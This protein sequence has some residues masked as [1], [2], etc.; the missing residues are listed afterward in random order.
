M[1]Q[2]ASVLS[3]AL[4]KINDLKSARSPKVRDRKAFEESAFGR[5]WQSDTCYMPNITENGVSRRTYLVMIVDDFSRMIVG[6][7]IFY[8]DNAYNFQILLKTAIETYG[9]PSKLYLDNGSPYSNEQL[10]RICASV[11]IVEFI[12]QSATVRPKARLREISAP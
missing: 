7:R 8:S 6:G 1:P 12:R 5:L 2:P 10:S 4:M 9:I 11:G 3:S